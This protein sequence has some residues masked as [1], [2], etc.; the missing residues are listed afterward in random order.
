MFVFVVAT[1]NHIKIQAL[2]LF[3]QLATSTFA[4]DTV[5]ILTDWSNFGC[6]ACHKNLIG[7][8]KLITSDTA[9][10]NFNTQIMSKLND[11]AA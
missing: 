9:F 6:R 3:S 4:D 11:G 8:V 10:M 7:K 1:L 5:I 2:K